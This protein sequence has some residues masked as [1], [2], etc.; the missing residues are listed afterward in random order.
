MITSREIRL[1]SR[2]VGMP[3]ADNFEL[4]TVSVSRPAPGE[5]QVQNL[6]MTVDP[7]MRGRMADRAIYTPSS[8]TGK[9]VPAPA[10]MAEMHDL[11]VGPTGDGPT[12]GGPGLC[13]C[14][15]AND[16]DARFCKSC[17]AR[18]QVAS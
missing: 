9:A 15:T 4:A 8:R 6:W 7:Y 5:V 2:P 10:R 17:G 3:S 12:G 1:K 14:G 16:S 13:A 18:L 11:K